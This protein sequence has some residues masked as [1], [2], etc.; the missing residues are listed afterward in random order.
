MFSSG[1]GRLLNFHFSKTLEQMKKEHIK[2][3]IQ[4]VERMLKP[5]EKSQ[6]NVYFFKVF[7]TEKKVQ[8][9]DH[10]KVI[11]FLRNQWVRAENQKA[12]T[13]NHAQSCLFSPMFCLFVLQL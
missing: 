3:Q 9:R 7:F 2:T 10:G 12:K 8:A 1:F 13:T 5:V 6:V 4:G 11:F